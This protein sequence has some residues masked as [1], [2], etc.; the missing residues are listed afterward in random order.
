M[1]SACSIK[2][3]AELILDASLDCF[4]VRRV[5]A[6]GQWRGQDV[7]NGLCKCGQAFGGHCSQEVALTDQVHRVKVLT[8]ENQGKRFAVIR[9]LGCEPNPFNVTL[10]EV[11]EIFRRIAFAVRIGLL[12]AARARQKQITDVIG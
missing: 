2:L 3:R 7:A 12:V 8:Q 1:E 10:M 6:I 11:L 5:A 4:P 9:D